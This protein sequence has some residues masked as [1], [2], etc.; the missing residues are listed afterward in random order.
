MFEEEM[1]V[2]TESDPLVGSGKSTSIPARLRSISSDSDF[3]EMS[4]QEILDKAK[5]SGLDLMFLISL[6]LI[7]IADSMQ[8]CY[9]AIVLPVLK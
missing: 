1:K 3:K 9:I 2:V 8:A 7:A 5:F 6:G 4:V